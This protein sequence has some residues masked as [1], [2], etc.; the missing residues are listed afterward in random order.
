[1]VVVAVDM[2]V[3]VICCDACDACDCCGGVDHV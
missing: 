1:M 3:L 2:S